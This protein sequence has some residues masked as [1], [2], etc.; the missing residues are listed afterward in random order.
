MADRYAFQSPFSRGAGSD[1]WFTVGS[2]A[3]TTTMIV[4]ALGLLGILAVVVEGGFGVVGQG[5]QL[6]PEAITRGQVWRFITYPIPPNAGFFWALLGLVFFFLIGSQFESLLGRKPYAGLIAALVLIP[7]I[8]GAVIAVLTGADS[9]IPFGLSTLF[10]GVAAGFSA[11]MPQARSFFGIPFWG[12]VVFIFVIRILEFI[13]LRSLVGL[14]MILSA[15]F[16]GL[17]VTRS[18]GFSTVEWIPSIGLP[19]SMTGNSAP[20]TS[21]PKRKR[22]RSKGKGNLRSVPAA[23][24]AQSDAEIDSLLDQVNEQ[25]IDSLSKQQ[26]QALERHA[27]EMRKR[28]DG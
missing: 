8:L 9:I 23:P 6:Q 27:K 14:V 18:L 4:T 20:S 11:A 16:V 25:G 10:L 22:S 15:G 2:M 26:R 17:V 5:L 21:K 1:P 28:R 13:T 7:G 12:V 19:G 3:F 24:T